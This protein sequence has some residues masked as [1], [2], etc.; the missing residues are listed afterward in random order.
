M[1]TTQVLLDG[2]RIAES[3]RWHDGRLWFCHWGAD[4]IVA[5]APDGSA[6]VLLHAPELGPHTIDW[7]PDGR[8]LMIAKNRP[9]LLLRQE[10]DGSFETHADLRHL[11]SGWNEMV[12]LPDGRVY[13]DGTDL[14]LLGF[15]RGAAEFVPGI[16]ALVTP[17]GSAR[18]V[19]EDIRFGNGMAVTPDGG[20][21]VLADSLARTLVAFT[22]D[23][24]G[25][26]SGRRVWA[27]DVAPDGICIDADGAV[28]TS[29]AAFGR[30]EDEKDCVRVADGG[31]VLDRF[32][33]DRSSFAVMLGG[34][35][36]QTLYVLAARWNHEDP[37]GGPRTGQVL[38]AAAPAPGAGWPYAG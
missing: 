27:S 37:F 15:F 16:V 12:A 26:L 20:T 31:E 13:V 19:A 11:A 18:T 25:G 14:D 29:A 35:Q 5:L 32:T 28:W 9:G 38:A 7:L 1:T 36:R 10:A 24:D 21:L 17:D 34:P 4:E 6:E 22:I 30:P 33:I 8:M 23:A 3:P 2:L